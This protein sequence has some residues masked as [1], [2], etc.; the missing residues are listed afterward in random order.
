[1]DIIDLVNEDLCEVD[2]R[3]K[4]KE[5]LIYKIADMLTRKFE[6]MTA[7]EI[8]DALMEREKLGSTGFGDGLAIPHAKLKNIDTFAICIVTLK[9]GIDYESI[10]RKKVKVAVAILGPEDRQKDYLRL[11][12]G[13][14]KNV[15]NKSVLAEMISAPSVSALKEAFIKSTI[16]LEEIHKRKTKNKLLIIHLSEHKY[17]DD[18]IQ[19]LLEREVSDAVVTDSTGVESF[20]AESP[21]FSGFLNFL[22]DRKGDY[23]TIM[24]AVNEEEIPALIQDI[25]EIMG[26]LDKHTGIQVMSLDVEFIKGAISS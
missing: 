18:I 20:L 2:F 9:K 23:K 14:S 11:L 3:V 12:A 19:G 22:A 7:G 10:D 17:F 15:R 4:T 25:E 26:D 8:F 21:L 13:V 1:M 5:D 16:S 24:V 6:H